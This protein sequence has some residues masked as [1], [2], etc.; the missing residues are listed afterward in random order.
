MKE[1]SDFLAASKI[2][3]VDF[4]CYTNFCRANTYSYSLKRLA[5]ISA[6]TNIQRISVKVR[7]SRRPDVLIDVT[8]KKSNLL[9]HDQILKIAQN[10]LK[11]STSNNTTV[12]MPSPP[13]PAPST[14]SNFFDTQKPVT[15]KTAIKK[16]AAPKKPAV[17]KPFA[18]NHPHRF[19]SDGKANLFQANQGMFGVE[20]IPQGTSKED[21]NERRKF[22]SNFYKAWQ[23][24]NPDGCIEN[25]FLR[26]F[27]YV[28][29]DSRKETMQHAAKRYKSTAAIMY[30]SEILRYAK[31]VK[32]D[33]PKSN[34]NQSDFSSTIIME[35][36]KVGFGKIKLTVGLKNSGR[37]VQYCVRFLS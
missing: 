14:K 28:N 27:I 18:E 21:V 37:N 10:A 12:T 19:S 23:I 33:T 25:D 6:I 7:N 4:D 2:T 36:N 32:I 13:K 3:L 16:P 11:K 8:D 1:L 29:A 9:P 15:K 31:T 20:N 5:T 22:I 30:L 35:Y 34:K 24:A 26:Q 17:K